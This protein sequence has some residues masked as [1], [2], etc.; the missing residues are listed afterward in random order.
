MLPLQDRNVILST[1]LPDDP[2][3]EQIVEM[4]KGQT[5]GGSNVI[6]LYIKNELVGSATQLMPIQN[7]SGKYEL[8]RA[9]LKKE[10]RKGDRL[11]VVG[12]QYIFN[13]VIFIEYFGWI[14]Y[15]IINKPQVLLDKTFKVLAAI[16]IGPK[17]DGFILYEKIC[18]ETAMEE[19]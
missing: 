5:V 11:K 4:P 6:N 15:G 18:L 12:R 1:L 10:I 3:P 16:P 7:V 17:S 2:K 14:G 13:S 19:K 8:I 9:S